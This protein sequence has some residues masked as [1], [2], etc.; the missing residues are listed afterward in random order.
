[1]IDIKEYDNAIQ[2]SNDEAEKN[3][4][5]LEMQTALI[6]NNNEKRRTDKLLKTYQSEWIQLYTKPKFDGNLF[7]FYP[8]KVKKIVMSPFGLMELYEN[9]KEPP[10]TLPF[11]IGSIS[12]KKQ[13]YYLL[14]DTT[15]YNDNT[16]SQKISGDVL[17][18]GFNSETNQLRRIYVVHAPVSRSLFTTMFSSLDTSSVVQQTRKTELNS[19]ILYNEKEYNMLYYTYDIKNLRKGTSKLTILNSVKLLSIRINIEDYLYVV[20]TNGTSEDP[21]GGTFINLFFSV[22][23]ISS[24][25][26]NV[27]FNGMIIR[28]RTDFD[29]TFNKLMK[30]DISGKQI[31]VV[32]DDKQIQKI[33]EEIA[34]TQMKKDTYFNTTY[35]DPI[36]LP[37][38]LDQINDYDIKIGILKQKLVTQKKK[39]EIYKNTTKN[40][41]ITLFTSKGYDYSSNHITF[42]PSTTN[43]I[44]MNTNGSFVVVDKMSDTLDTDIMKFTIKSVVNETDKYIVS[45]MLPGN[46]TVD[47]LS[48][49]PDLHME[50]TTNLVY[51]RSPSGLGP[52][53]VKKRNKPPDDLETRTNAV[54]FYSDSYYK[55]L[56]DF[57]FVN[58]QSDVNHIPLKFK[59]EKKTYKIMSIMNS[60]NYYITLYKE[61]KKN[62]H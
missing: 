8:D 15:S 35:E 6:Y 42:D 60:T 52:L 28:P 12:N 48:N 50:D 1:M 37:V 23:D 29:V 2:I 7:V 57:F 43:A 21:Y 54:S 16:L 34:E 4:L 17:D 38:F 25:T 47:V 41:N 9:E 3:Q 5:E 19:V 33:N 32:E 46:K 59:D 61:I 20:L 49:V 58:P 14:Y 22:S 24:Y 62:I 11:T 36:G 31:V 13:D 55:T 45:L 27:T 10:L 26:N 30:T 53:F 39:I 18:T 44:F 40:N 56:Y 51:I